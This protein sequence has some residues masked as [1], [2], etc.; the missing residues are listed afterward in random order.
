MPWREAIG[1]NHAQQIQCQHVGRAL[2]DRQHLDITQQL[3]QTGVLDITRAT[4]A[5]QHL[6]GDGDGIARRAE[7]DHR[8]QQT[9]QL[10]LCLPMTVLDPSKLADHGPG[11]GR[12]R[13][14]IGLQQRQRSAMQRQLDQ[15]TAEGAAAPSIALGQR[16]TPAHQAAGRDCVPGSGQVQY[17]CDRGHAALQT[18][19]RLGRGSVEQ[20]LGGRQLARTELVLEPQNLDLLQASVGIMRLNIEQR[21]TTRAVG[22]AFRARQRQCHLRGRRRGEPLAAMQAPLAVVIAPRHGLAAA[23]VGAADGLGHPLARSPERIS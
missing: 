9:L 12:S 16:Q 21:K 5:L 14:E 20:Q 6:G 18:G 22:T 1:L 11:R 13:G 3:R 23:Y 19:H 2:P 4:K 8:C 15:Q 10:R 7:L 17:R